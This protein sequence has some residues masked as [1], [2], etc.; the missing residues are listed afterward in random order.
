MLPLESGP[1]RRLCLTFR[2]IDRYCDGGRACRKCQLYSVIMASVMPAS[3]VSLHVKQTRKM[4][5][6]LANAVSSIRMTDHRQKRV[7]TN[8]GSLLIILGVQKH[9]GGYSCA[10]R[11]MIC[12]F[13]AILFIYCGKHR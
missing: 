3:V 4:I 10:M 5:E 8:R 7:H 9:D 2:L 13:N 1:R 6:G 11:F 12:R